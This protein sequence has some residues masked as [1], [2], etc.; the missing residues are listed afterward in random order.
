[1]LDEPLISLPAQFFMMKRAILLEFSRKISYEI[2]LVAVSPWIL[3]AVVLP[4]TRKIVSHRLVSLKTLLVVL[5]C[6]IT[7][8]SIVGRMSW[9]VMYGKQKNII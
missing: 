2:S 7:S 8:L 9:L 4:S 1:M 3:K 6:C 5:T